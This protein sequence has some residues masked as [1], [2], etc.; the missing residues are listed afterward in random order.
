MGFTLRAA[1][2]DLPDDAE[3]TVAELNPVV[4]EWCEGPLVSLI[5]G[6]ATD[7]RVT[8]AITDVAVRIR[9]VARDAEARRFD[10]IILDMYEG[11][12]THVRPHDPLY[13]PFALLQAKNALAENGVLAVWC[14]GPSTGF[15]RSL[16]AAGFRYR[17]AR[18]GRGARIHHVYIAKQVRRAGPPIPC[19]RPVK[20]AGGTG[21]AARDDAATADG[22]AQPSGRRTTRSHVPTRRRR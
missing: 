15:E 1:L 4:V 5:S 3:V 21:G 17:I 6:A 7:P 14:E 16:H 18:P 20:N 8:M 12:L 2:D 9:D 22:T 19:D 10:A 13:G 11:P